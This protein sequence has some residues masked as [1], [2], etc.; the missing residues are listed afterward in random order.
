MSGQDGVNGQGYITTA[1]MGLF[2]GT[3]ADAG[4]YL[5]LSWDGNN[6]DTIYYFRRDGILETPKLFVGGSSTSSYAL[7]TPSFICDSWV[8]TKNSTGWYNET[9]DGGWY[10]ND[11]TYVR[12]YNSK[13]V[14]VGNN[15]YV[16]TTAGGGTG[17]ALYSTSAPT[18]Y[19]IHMSTTGNYNKHGDVQSDWA[20]YFNMNAVSQRGWI[21]RAG[22]TNVASVSC[23]GIGTFSSVGNGDS[24]I[25]YP[26]GGSYKNG[27]SGTTGY[28][29]ITLPAAAYNSAT[30]VRFK[31]S[32][33][34][35]ALMG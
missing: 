6:S 2:H 31:V 12:S 19:G 17:L 32:I 35:K 18:V 29:T 24:Y 7:A 11:G 28:L 13:A 5:G 33:F 30:M 25:A 15:I 14:L 26:S 22:D 23:N 21:F 20:T 4:I 1:V 34:K 16:G 9:H 3:P 10:M 8:R 27:G